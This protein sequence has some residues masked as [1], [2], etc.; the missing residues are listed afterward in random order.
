MIFSSPAFLL[1]FFPIYLLICVGGLASPLVLTFLSIGFFYANDPSW[2]IAFIIWLLILYPIIHLQTVTILLKVILLLCPLILFKYLLGDTIDGIAISIPLGISFW[3]FQLIT[4][5]TEF[6]KKRVGIIRYLEYVTF[7]PQ[8]I[9]GPIV[10]AREFLQQNHLKRTLVRRSKFVTLG[11][12]IFSIGVIKKCGVAD[13]IIGVLSTLPDDFSSSLL[14][15]PIWGLACLL[16]VYFDFTGYS[17]M[18]I[19]LGLMAGI[20]LPVNFANPL[21]F[22]DPVEFWNLWHISLTRFFRDYLFNR[23]VIWSV[24]RDYPEITTMLIMVFY[25][26]ILGLWHGPTTNF[27]IFGLLNGLLVTA[28]AVFPAPR[29][30]LAI[31][32]SSIIW[33]LLIYSSF[34]FFFFDPNTIAISIESLPTIKQTLILVFCLFLGMIVPDGVYFLKLPGKQGY[35][36]YLF[37]A[38][39]SLAKVLVHNKALAAPLLLLI[40]LMTTSTSTG[41]FIYFEF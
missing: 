26:F 10:R 1:I 12:M 14:T 8:L 5:T 21:A 30:S 9:A 39:H 23:M 33:H 11:C 22:K 41:S 35:T 2:C 7:F 32:G 17:D 3:S 15:L 37:E 31:I 13:P 27:L 28:C 18:A 6:N 38:R 19:G 36:N 16:A 40:A 24:R 25:F 4:Y 34:Y 29:G 20:R